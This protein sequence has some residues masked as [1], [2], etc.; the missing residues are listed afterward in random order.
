MERASAVGAS[1]LYMCGLGYAYAAAG[2]KV[3]AR[4]VIDAL[5]QGTDRNYTPAYF[6]ASIYGELGEKER[7]FDWLQRG[8]DERDPQVAYL[9]VDPFMDPL[10]SDSRFDALVRK[11][12]FPQ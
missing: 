2:N 3:K 12:G 1:P 10:R 4:A 9:L 7:A 6:I 8:Y 5:K 11:L